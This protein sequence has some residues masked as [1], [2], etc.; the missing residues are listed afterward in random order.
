METQYL[1]WFGHEASMLLHSNAHST[2]LCLGTQTYRLSLTDTWQSTRFYFQGSCTHTVTNWLAFG[3]GTNCTLSFWT[4]IQMDTLSTWSI[5]TKSCSALFWDRF[6]HSVKLFV[7]FQTDLAVLKPT[8]SAVRWNRS[9]E[10]EKKAT[11][12]LRRLGLSN[13]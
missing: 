5:R 4:S 13:I 3:P 10:G 6:Q 1:L 9:G 8:Q 11:E 7:C 2:P 12:I